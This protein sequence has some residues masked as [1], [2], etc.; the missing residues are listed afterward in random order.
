MKIVCI[1]ASFVPSTT[2]NSIQVLKATQALAEPGHEVTLLV[3]GTRSLDWEAIRHQYGLRTRFEIRWIPE[4]LTFR[5]YDFAFRAMVEAK[6]LAPDFIYTWVLQAGVLSLWNR[7]PAILEIHDRIKGK[8]GP[9]LFRWFWQSRT[10]RRVLTNTAALRQSLIQQ[11]HL[12]NADQTI[13]VGPNGVELERYDHLP[14]ASEAREQLGL[15]DGFTVGYTGHF[16]AGRGLELMAQLAKTQPDMRFLWVG[17]QPDDVAY[18]S[19][20]LA[21][22]G[23]TNVTLTGFVDNADLPLYQAAADVLLMPYGTQIAGS[24]GGNS[25][26]IASP[27]KMFEYMAAG[28][29]IITSDLPVIHEVLD[30]T[31]AI[32]CQPENVDEWHHALNYLQSDSRVRQSLAKAA[33]MAVSQYTWQARARSVLKG[34]LP[35]E[36]GDQE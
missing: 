5:R 7:I 1:A 29:A 31:M 11:F 36:T 27:M 15:P 33:R 13:F 8:L 20:H 9:Q 4:N 23:I 19:N 21:D 24:G 12:E 32:F 30:E 16:Y 10:A 34:W 17:G 35:E 3:P 18:W 26:D 22:E 28:R 25:A 6:R 14:S 2:A